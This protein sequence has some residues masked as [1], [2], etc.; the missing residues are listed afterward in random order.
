[1][2]D[3]PGSRRWPLVAAALLL[4]IAFLM[5]TAPAS[6]LAWR[7]ARA[8]NNTAS[9]ERAEGGVWRGRASA[10]VINAPGVAPQRLSN[11][12][13]KLNGVRLLRGQLAVDITLDGSSAKAAGTL[14]VRPHSIQLIQSNITLPASTIAAFFPALQLGRAGGQVTARAE[15]IVFREGAALGEAE[16]D[17]INASTALSAVNPL[18]TYRLKAKAKDGPAQFEITTVNGALRIAGSGTWSAAKGLSF[19]AVARAEPLE[20][21]N[22]RNLLLMLGRD[23]GNGN[24]QLQHA[25]R[26]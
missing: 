7:V 22:L 9:L 1:M 3:L 23:D 2:P 8:S 21:A 26:P 6:L 20:A 4:Y 11:A 14:V 10:F 13:W 17:W 5:I 19:T 12:T 25:S 16:I 18:G 15:D 24:Y